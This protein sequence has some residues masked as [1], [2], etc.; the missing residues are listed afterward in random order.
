MAQMVQNVFVFFFDFLV[1]FRFKKFNSH[2]LDLSYYSKLY[3]Q[4]EPTKIFRWKLTLQQT[5]F[6]P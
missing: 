6:F 4:L 3:L 1:R 5:A 2:Y